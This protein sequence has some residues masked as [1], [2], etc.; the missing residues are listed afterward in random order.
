MNFGENVAGGDGWIG[1]GWGGDG[2]DWSLVL[3][4]GIWWGNNIQYKYLVDN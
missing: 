2:A 3:T 1:G 4:Y